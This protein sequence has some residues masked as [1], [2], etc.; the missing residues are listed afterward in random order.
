M[1]AYVSGDLEYCIYY[2]EHRCG[3]EGGNRTR[4]SEETGF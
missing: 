4:T 1:N 3:A 2:I